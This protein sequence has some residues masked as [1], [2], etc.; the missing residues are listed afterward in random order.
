MMSLNLR[1]QEDQITKRDSRR[2]TEGGCSLGSGSSACAPRAANNWTVLELRERV[3]GVFC[4]R[5]GCS[6]RRIPRRGPCAYPRMPS[7]TSDP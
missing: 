7:P 2:T 6:S 5:R 1:R 3:V 4:N